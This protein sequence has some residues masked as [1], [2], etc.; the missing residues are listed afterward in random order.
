MPDGFDPQ[1]IELLYQSVNDPGLWQVALEK[2]VEAFESDHATLF[3]NKHSALTMP[4]YVAAG[5]REDDQARYATPEADRIWTPWQMAL[6]SGIATSQ[7]TII[8]DDEFEKTAGY[9]ELVRPTQC[10]YGGFIQQ[11]VPHLSFHLAICRPRNRGP[12]ENDEI[13]RLQ[14]LLPHLTTTMLLQRRLR[15]LE[16]RA[17]SLSGAI[18][19]FEYGAVL[20]D[21]NG[22]PTLVNRRASH[23][24]NDCDGLTLCDQGLRA[25]NTATN[26]ELLAAIRK[27]AHSSSGDVHNIRIPRAAPRP[28]LLLD[29]MPVARIS[30]AEGGRMPCVVIFIT[31]PDALPIIDSE[32]LAES[33]RLT[34][35]EAEI[36]ALLAAGA[37]VETIAARLSLAV[38][39][40]RFNLKRVF[41][42]TGARTQAAVVALARGFT[43]RGDL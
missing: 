35:R 43:R 6:P 19:R 5:L 24:L 3:T 39:T 31:E 9:Q 42:K 29:I 34:P 28:P 38:G 7:Q 17:N 13:A 10:F 18:E 32:A 27:A 37:N 1:L 15:A 2:I 22:C 40:V 30:A 41:E 20:C 21:A 4:F 8:R 12:F 16:Q 11:D 26:D 23:L 25:S 14:R 36:A 33:Y